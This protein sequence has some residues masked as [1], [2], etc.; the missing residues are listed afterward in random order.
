LRVRPVLRKHP[1]LNIKKEPVDV[2][3]Y[4]SYMADSGKILSKVNE[5]DYAGLVVEGQGAGFCAEWVFDYIVEIHKKIPVVFSTRIGNGEPLTLSYG[6]GYG[7]PSYLVEH[8][9]LNSN[10][11]DSRKARI[12][13]ML[14]IM[15][16]CT[17]EQMQQSFNMYS[18]YY[19]Q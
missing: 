17:K 16:N 5:L 2:L 11:L 18:K 15:S 13:L 8:G 3:L 12:L 6:N 1:W 14:L 7:M 9:Y 4:T 10:Q 19:L